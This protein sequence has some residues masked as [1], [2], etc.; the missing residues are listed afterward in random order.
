MGYES[1]PSYP[2][3]WSNFVLKQEVC[4]D[5]GYFFEVDLEYPKELHD[6]HD[7]YPLAPEHIEIQE[8]MLSD[9]QLKI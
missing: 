3:Y 2:E 9:Y 6:T 1:I 5:T 8:S 7:Q 4:Q